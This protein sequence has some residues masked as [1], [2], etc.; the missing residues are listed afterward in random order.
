MTIENKNMKKLLSTGKMVALAAGIVGAAQ[1]ASA[2][3]VN[4]TYTGETLG[5]VGMTIHTASGSENVQVGQFVMTTSN[6]NFSSTLL[7]YCTDI[8]AALATG[9]SG[10]NYTPTA[11][12]AATG[13][14][15]AWISGGIQNAAKL[16]FNDKGAA[17]S[18]VQTAG[19][20][21]AIWELLYNSYSSTTTYTD[22]TLTTGGTGGNKGFYIT[23]SGL[24]S[25]GT[26]NS[27]GLAEDYAEALLNNFKNLTTD[28]NVEWLAPTDSHGNT[29]GSQGLL[30][31]LPGTTTLT[32]PDVSS[33]LPLFGMAIMALGVASRK[34]SGN[35]A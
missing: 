23:S 1:V 26:E 34:L 20:Q 5:G 33:T 32:A 16:W 18:A 21:I 4:Y 31:Q 25:N 17:T 19:L 8:G 28:G 12:S 29:T 22:A 15:P 6:P 35:K 30:Y 14:A 2:V 13:V 24:N 27:I 11:L 7:T 10:Y 3:E 9:S